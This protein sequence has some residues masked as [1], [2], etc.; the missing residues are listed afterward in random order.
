MKLIREEVCLHHWREVLDEVRKDCTVKT[1]HFA[2]VVTNVR[3][4]DAEEF[5]DDHRVLNKDRSIR[6]D[7]FEDS[8]C[9]LSNAESW[10][11]E[12]CH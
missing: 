8:C 5:V 2:L 1:C 12:E 6:C 7:S 9:S 11:L 3:D 4:D 10:V